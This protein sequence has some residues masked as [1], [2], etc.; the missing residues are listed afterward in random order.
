[1]NS[2]FALLRPEVSRLDSLTGLRRNTP[3]HAPRGQ[4]Y[5]AGK[6]GEAPWIKDYFSCPAPA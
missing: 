4:G 2:Y 3:S 6:D 1:M 5:F